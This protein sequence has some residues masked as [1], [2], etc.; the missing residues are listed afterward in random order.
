MPKEIGSNVTKEQMKEMLSTGNF[1]AWIHGK[2]G[3]QVSS[4]FDGLDSKDIDE[5]YEENKTA[6]AAIHKG[7]AIASE[8]KIMRAL[9]NMANLGYEQGLQNACVAA[10]D[11]DPILLQAI[12]SI[13]TEGNPRTEDGDN[14]GLFMQQGVSGT[15][16]PQ[17]QVA[18]AIIKLAF[19]TKEQSAA[20]KEDNPEGKNIEKVKAK[21]LEKIKQAMDGR[22]KNRNRKNSFKRPRLTINGLEEKWRNPIGDI[23]S[24]AGWNDQLEELNTPD[25]MFGEDWAVAAGEF[26]W[27]LPAVVKAY[28]IIRNGKKN[29]SQAST[30]INGGDEG[31]EFPLA[32]KDLARAYLVQDF[33]VSSIES[34][35]CSV[36]DGIIIKLP[37]GTQ[38]YS[39]CKGKKTALAYDESIGNYTNI[40]DESCNY[41]YTIAGLQNMQGGAG[42]I[43]KSGL[44]GTSTEKLIIK[45]YDENGRS[46][47]SP[48]GVWSR[49]CFN[50]S[51]EKS[52]GQQIADINAQMTS[53]T[54]DDIGGVKRGATLSNTSS[55]TSAGAESTKASKMLNK[56]LKKS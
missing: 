1:S 38:V 23:Q 14:G 50:A 42:M 34:T 55:S 24:W 18:K 5:L 47:I 2:D 28:D 46:Y 21:A 17:N 8:E 39:P 53:V 22:K 32:T 19:G 48:K 9:E 20:K 37:A 12:A 44:I 52:I 56:A 16:K 25:A 54:D 41:I 27:V 7:F 29:L 10:E 15:S 26:S 40:S 35:V 11:A 36:S 45:V 30:N 49:I 31:A 6:I 51:K 43:R 4:I 13:I 3:R 33:G